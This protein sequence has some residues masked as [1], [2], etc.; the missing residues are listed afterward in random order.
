L[1]S[2]GDDWFRAEQEFIQSSDLPSR[3]PFSSL[4]MEPV[5]SCTA[6]RVRDPAK[7]TH[8]ECCDSSPS[9]HATKHAAATGHPIITSFEPGGDWF[10]DYEKQG[11]IKG[12]EL[13]APHAH[14]EN[15]PVPGPAGRVS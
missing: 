13:L 2:P 12:A 1:G 10:F 11:M 4:T 7:R 14:P 3:L 9:Q 5:G 6:H 15:Q 8:I